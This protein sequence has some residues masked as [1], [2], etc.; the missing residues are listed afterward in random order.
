MLKRLRKIIQAEH[1]TDYSI[2]QRVATKKMEQR[3][4]VVSQIQRK[5]FKSYIVMEHR[6][7]DVLIT[8]DENGLI[9]N[10]CQ[11]HKNWLLTFFS[12]ER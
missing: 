2:S 1:L 4:W 8:I 5:W 9:K 3:G 10:K 6:N 12:S 7:E 11:D